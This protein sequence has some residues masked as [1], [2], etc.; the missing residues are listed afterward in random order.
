MSGHRGGEQV[1]RAGLR[2][3][4][5]R[6]L[7]E[8]GR[9][10]RFFT[11]L[12]RL[13]DRVTPVIG[14][15]GVPPQ[16]L[17]GSGFDGIAN[18]G[19]CT[20][21]LLPT[22]RHILTAA[23]C[24]DDDGDGVA[25]STNYSVT[26]NMPGD[27]V[28][29]MN[30]PQANVIV[31]PMWGGGDNISDG[32]DV[33]VMILPN[34]APV[35]A[36]RFSIADPKDGT[37][38]ADPTASSF[39]DSSGMITANDV[40]NTNDILIR[41]LDGPNAGLARTVSN[42]DDTTQVIT[43]NSAFPNVPNVGDTFEY[44]FRGSQ[45]IGYGNTGTGTEGQQTGTSGIKRVGYNQLESTDD[46]NGGD[47]G[48]MFQNGIIGA[49]FQMPPAG[50]DTSEAALG[51]G[52][53]GGPL[54]VGRSIIGIASYG[55]GGADFDSSDF[56][57]Y[58]PQFTTSFIDPILT[59]AG[60]LTLD[61]DDQDDGQDGVPDLISVVVDNTD[62]DITIFVNG[63]SLG[64]VDL[65]EVTELRL[66]G[67]NDD[68][69]FIIEGDFD[70][71]V[72]VDGRRGN[73][74]LRIRRS[75]RDDDLVYRPGSNTG[76]GEIDVDTGSIVSTITFEDLEPLLIS[77]VASYTLKTTDRTVLTVAQAGP[78][79]NIVTG[80]HDG[81]VAFESVTF[82]DVDE[83]II[84][85]DDVF[86]ENDEF[87]VLTPLV[88]EDLDT[89]TIRS[90]G[91]NDT[92]TI[93]TNFRLPSSGGSFTFDAGTG[94][95]DL[96]KATGDS[97]LILSDTS[98]A[99]VGSATGAS[100]GTLLLSGVEEAILTGGMLA[101]VI[102]AAGFSGSLVLN[103]GDG[104]D[105]LTGG[106]GQNSVYGN[107][108]SDTLISVNGSGLYEG[109]EGNDHL[110]FFGSAV[111]GN[112]LAVLAN[113]VGVVITSSVGSRNLGVHTVESIFLGAS[114]S[115]D[116]I[117]VGNLRDTDV[118]LVTLDLGLD[119][120][121]D[122]V[123]I[124]NPN[125]ADEVS[126]TT[127]GPGMVNVEQTQNANVVILN[128]LAS[129]P[130]GPN[131]DVL[132]LNTNAGN[133]TVMASPEASE[134]IGLVINAGDG[135]DFVMAN[136]TI[137]GGR[138]NDN[139]SGAGGLCPVTIDGGEGDDQICG[140]D[141]NDLLNGGAGNDSIYG[142]GGDDT[143]NG[144]DGNDLLAGNDGNDTINGD[145][146]ND[147]IGGGAG[148][149]TIAGGLGDD[150]IYGDSDADCGESSLQP[151][152]SGQGND[153]LN[154]NVGNDT[155]SGEGGDDAIFGDE[156]DD[157]LSG[158]DGNDTIS[159]GDGDDTI[160][161]D[162][163]NDT[164]SGADGDDI[165]SGGDGNDT[166]S[167]GDGNDTISGGD[168]ND[169]IQGNL[170]DDLLVGDEGDDLIHGGLGADTIYGV[171][172]RDRLCGGLA[173]GEPGN[174]EL[175]G[176]D[177]ISGGND[178]DA[179]VGDAGDDTLFGDDGNDQIWG[180]AGND[181]L[182]GGTGNDAMVGG[183]GDD[184]LNG[185]DGNDLMFGLTGNDTLWGGNDDDSMYGGDGDDVMLGG[186]PETANTVHGPR[187]PSLPS[188][189]NDVMLG[190]LGFDHVDGGNGDNI[191]DAGDDGL[192]ETVLAGVG[193]DIGFSHRIRGHKV[194]DR[195]ALDGGHNQD[196]HRGGLVEPAIPD[197]VC[198]FVVFAQ[199]EPVVT[200][201]P[202]PVHV[203]LH[204]GASRPR[205]WAPRTRPVVV[206][207]TQVRRRLPLVSTQQ[208]INQPT[209]ARYWSLRSAPQSTLAGLGPMARL[210]A[211]R[212][213]RS[214]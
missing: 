27:R 3:S 126:I 23:H 156:G 26:F 7:A 105:V 101:N 205:S 73:D 168:D 147:T 47:G 164:I 74:E 67:S 183:A 92:L 42:L 80:T 9:K 187:N 146:G 89:F 129:C 45:I 110:E 158:G 38:G 140:N 120:V 53:S 154:G 208:P 176:N 155:I 117:Q 8:E 157:T 177:L 174:P 171:D 191:L 131:D 213:G 132:I 57:A 178:D 112:N 56:W 206:R 65:A 24:V 75:G 103:G 70:L 12:E 104:N 94:S 1:R 96:I 49:L 106:S 16:V 17:P 90:F 169:E 162:D 165:I 66:I 119:A 25:D 195:M 203:P 172:G 125:I 36:E 84:E 149:D 166:I 48:S 114:T 122:T 179:I 51:Q 18:L 202:G 97:D 127:P 136:G 15:I 83:F 212:G 148:D 204:N 197:E 138:G 52:D 78:D 63:R 77:N 32:F 150:L 88:A 137:N 40:R 60:P 113:G 62:D 188:D 6:H 128:S 100:Q 116:D 152:A 102:N 167:G 28:I 123:S 189:G 4:A 5:R 185:G 139:L 209:P 21:S 41:F 19:G 93:G 44:I 145:A 201:A 14:A 46:L 111:I 55:R 210:L 64:S 22:G 107:A 118:R 133:D 31:H 175:D 200:P 71:P 108:G 35:G 58:A 95:G 186:T 72:F 141:G 59:Q 2:G 30:V 184:F 161:G 43:V 91:G 196:R 182:H 99:S 160:S 29:R 130:F 79:R 115:S 142:A 163:G 68:D 192:V 34:Y 86:S 61:M 159:G 85:T 81:G 211:R 76:D 199:P 39:V 13:E 153:T 11:S 134:E 109:G 54:L 82:F 194:S 181:A 143:I 50:F 37:V 20:G 180:S 124:E 10:R 193:N 121:R 198:D 69:T 87:T 135:N 190:G 144:G 33:A 214:V 98:L 207:P 170:G 173:P 151:I